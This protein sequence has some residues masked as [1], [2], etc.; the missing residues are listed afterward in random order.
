VRAFITGMGTQLGAAVAALLEDDPAM[1]TIVGVD[2]D[3]PRARLRSAQFHRVDG[4]DGERLAALVR[5]VSPTVVL[6]LGVFEPG[7]R[8]LSPAAERRTRAGTEALFRA[9]VDVRSVKRVVVRSG[10]EVYG[11]GRGRADV[12]DE[13][14]PARPSSS[15]GRSM[16]RVEQIATSAAKATGAGY[17]ALRFAPIVGP[18]QPSPLGRYLRLPVVPVPLR[19][20]PFTLLHPDDA[21]RA[22]AAAVP[23]DVGGVLNV[24]APGS[25]TAWQAARHGRRV[26]VPIAGPTWGPGWQG[27]RRIGEV[28]GAPVPDHVIELLRRG[29]LAD[30]RRAA[31][32]L[33]V[34]PGRD[35]RSIIEELY[36]W[37]APSH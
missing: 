32:V 26:P 6:H 33:K 12:P 9:V 1:D 34:R 13:T 8:W 36:A 23:A 4:R 7:G 22:T 24:V 10:I 31:R 5:E 28:L 14:M 11:R 35:A 15:F 27:V 20:Q 25:I 2:T 16:L 37:T 21:A 29:R 19:P 3:P 18:H 30:G 17:L